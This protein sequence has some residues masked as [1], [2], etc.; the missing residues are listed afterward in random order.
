ME[1]A[2]EAAAAGMPSSASFPLRTLAS[3]WAV[4]L[5]RSSVTAWLAT[6]ITCQRWQLKVELRNAHIIGMQGTGEME[7]KWHEKKG[8][9]EEDRGDWIRIVAG[10]RSDSEANR[11]TGVSISVK[12]SP[13]GARLM[14]GGSGRC[15]L[16]CSP[17]TF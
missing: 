5:I 9:Y 17:T 16:Q 12:R 1:Q 2:V 8:Y 6:P 11:M 13:S 4:Y 14:P 15:L 10:H 3:S 7:M